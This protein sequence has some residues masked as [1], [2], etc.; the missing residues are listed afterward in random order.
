[1]DM[2]EKLKKLNP[3][4]EFYDITDAA[5][6]PFGRVIE[7]INTA[8]IVGV[9]KSIKNVGDGSSYVATEPKFEALPIAAVIRDDLF[10]TLPTQV[11]Y[12]WGHNTMMNATEWHT[13]SEIN[14]AVTPI[15]LIL[16]QRA[17]IENGMID[18][19]KFKAFFVPEGAAIEVYATSLHYCACQVSDNGFGCV[20]ALPKDTNTKLTEK[21][22]DPKMIAKNKWLIAHID[23]KKMTDS[24]N[25]PG[26][27]GV[28]YEIKY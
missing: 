5:F 24:G 8:E 2:L 11:G 25:V 23:N 3:D 19:S 22:T 7:G 1:M 9:G 20:V 13:S 10:G 6:K 12:C 16:G 21:A 14:I 4:I 28:N 17:D 15:V 18:S 26:I 27:T